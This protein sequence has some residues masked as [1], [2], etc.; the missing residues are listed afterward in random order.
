MKKIFT[1][2]CSTMFGTLAFGQL[3]PNGDFEGGMTNWQGA[4]TTLVSTVN[5]TISGNTTT[6]YPAGGAKMAF[7][8]STTTT[9]VLIQKFAY[10]QRPNSFRYM[11]C[12]LPA[13]AGELGYGFVRLTK[14]NTTTSKVDTLLSVGVIMNGASYPWKE[15]IIELG[16]KYK[17]TGNPDTAYV[18]FTNSGGATHLTGTSLILDNIKF[19]ANNASI[20]E[21]TDA[22]RV[23]VGKP[24]ITPNPVVDKATINYQI[25]TASDVKIELYDMTGKLIKEIANEKKLNFGIYSAELDASDI[26]PGIYFYK[27]TTGSYSTTEKIIISR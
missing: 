24:T 4:N 10:T 14:Y 6:L 23:L 27:I 7:M 11:F 12:Y 13:G 1:I 3:V 19:S 20:K 8:Q 17:K 2:L 25:N 15:A 16:D 9:A 5:V 18:Y 21:I 22:N 26:N